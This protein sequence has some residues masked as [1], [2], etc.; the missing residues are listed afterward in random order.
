MSSLATGQKLLLAGYCRISVDE[1]LDRDNT[2]IENQ[3]AIITEY[4]SRYFPDHEL[5]LYEDRDR[6]GYTFEQREGYQ[7]L[8]RRLLSGEIPILIVK[9]FSRFSRRNSKGLVE[10][11][12]LRDAGVR[13]ISINDGVDY[14]TNDDWISIQFRFLVN[15]MPVTDTS[16]KVKSVISKAQRDG[17]WICNVPYGYVLTNSKTGAF[18][19]DE[20]AAE[21]VRKIFEL[22]NDGWG[23]GKIANYLT[24]QN[25][26][27]PRMTEIQRKE[28]RGEESKLKARPQ[29][30]V[31]TVCGIIENDFYIGTL[32]QHKYTRK[33]ING[34]DRKLDADEHIVFLNHHPGIV[35]YRT[36]AKA[37]EQKK[38]RTVTHYRGVK[39][40]DNVYSGL[41]YCGDCGAPM[42]SMSRSDLKPAYTCGT[43]H[44]RGRSGCTSHH[45]RVDVLDRL[46]KRYVQRVRDGSAAMIEELNRSMK[47][48]KDMVRQSEDAAQSLERQ[49]F[50]AREQLKAT[51][52][53]KIR[54][55]AKKPDQA[56]MLDELYEEIE[57]ELTERISG[58][59]NQLAL[60]M[61]RRNSVIQ[62]NRA[63][64][65]AFEIFD[66]ILNKPAL[67]KADLEIVI[68]RITVYE[69][70][71]D[72]KLKSDIDSLLRLGMLEEGANFPSDS[73]DSSKLTETIVQSAAKRPDKVYTVNVLCSG[74]PSRIRMVR[75]IS[76]GITTLP[77]SSMRLTIPV[78]FIRI[79]PPS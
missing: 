21:V 4:V 39:K 52:K 56:D 12:D 44:R 3:K 16:K 37:Q 64:K 8:R 65:T 1:E 29:W 63:A 72:I 74:S 47:N 26:P 49:L 6:S 43:Y 59:Q 51:A 30:S 53:Q 20:P 67:D 17:K 23:Y 50:D 57:Q 34:Q 42:F 68:D 15:E 14:P 33:K 2:S 79:A 60:T 11:E 69:D 32:R 28:S 13:I 31:I 22:Y 48:E 19:I 73:V 9:D 71:I 5:V 41:L 76:F 35:D 18:E 40:F 27:T 62:V 70:H 61:N 46:V 58:L 45:T 7:K 10:L 78:A 66:D 25:I 75:R 36:F 77:R 55:I 24:D 54:E 38:R